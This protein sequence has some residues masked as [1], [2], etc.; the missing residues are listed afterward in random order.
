LLVSWLWLDHQNVF[1]GPHDFIPGV[2]EAVPYVVLEPA[3]IA[4]PAP[5]SFFVGWLFQEVV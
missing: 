2:D 1:L 5:A 3:G 4:P